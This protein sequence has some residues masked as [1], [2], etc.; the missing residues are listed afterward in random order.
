VAGNKGHRRVLPSVL[1]YTPRRCLAL[2]ALEVFLPLE[3]LE[4][5]DANC[6]AMIVVMYKA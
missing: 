5:A 6:K 2:C 4:S 3:L 1:A